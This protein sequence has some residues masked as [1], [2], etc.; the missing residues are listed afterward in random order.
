[1][2]KPSTTRGEIFTAPP[3]PGRPS[4][5]PIGLS[6]N[7]FPKKKQNSDLNGFLSSEVSYVGVYSLALTT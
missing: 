2:H 5:K 6:I 7:K 3:C 4:P 1:M